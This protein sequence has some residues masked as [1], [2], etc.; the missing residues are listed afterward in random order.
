MDQERWNALCRRLGC[1]TS[2]EWFTT[3]ETAYSE[4]HRHYHTATHVQECLDL[5]DLNAGEA[6]HPDE[7]EFAIWLH[8]AVYAPL[9]KDNEERSADLAVQWLRACGLHAAAAERIR[10]LIIA[11]RH[12]DEPGT[13]DE[14]LLLDID[15]GILGAAP[16]RF[17][18]YEHQVRREYRWVPS[19]IF[20]R[21]RAQLLESFF[22]R[23]AVYRTKWFR[24]HREEAAKRNLSRAIDRASRRPD[25]RHS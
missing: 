9:R 8:D 1:R 16:D 15:L 14:A 10:R 19:F 13:N 23:E 25:G 18:E 21:R 2:D 7:I 6:E 3:L 12:V 24:E 22:D 11:T 17:D 20:R 5:L 4:R